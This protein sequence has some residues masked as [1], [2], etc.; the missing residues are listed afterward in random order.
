M[1]EEVVKRNRFLGESKYGETQHDWEK[2]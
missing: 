1:N 2:E